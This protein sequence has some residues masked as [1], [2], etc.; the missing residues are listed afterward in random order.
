MLKVARIVGDSRVV[1]EQREFFLEKL[2]RS[3]ERGTAGG[4]VEIVDRFESDQFLDVLKRQKE[5]VGWAVDKIQNAVEYVEEKIGGGERVENEVERLRIDVGELKEKV[6]L[7]EE[8]AERKNTSV[9]GGREKKEE[10]KEEAKE[11]NNNSNNNKRESNDSP[12]PNPD[13]IDAYISA[14]YDHAYYRSKLEKNV[15]LKPSDPLVS[16][17]YPSRFTHAA[18]YTGVD[19]VT[20]EW[21]EMKIKITKGAPAIGWHDIGRSMLRKH[22]RTQ[23]K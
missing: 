4:A 19:G 16:L 13:Y 9:E 2:N 14:K 17:S 8:A 12:P 23:R 1:R 7:L 5:E 15:H 22:T 21:N 20:E 10:R 18:G 11:D 3:M 6:Y